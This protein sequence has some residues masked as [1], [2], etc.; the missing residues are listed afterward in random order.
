MSTS[1]ATPS[2]SLGEATHDT[3]TLSGGTSPGGSMIFKLF[4]PNDPT[5]SKAPAFT[6]STQTIT[7]N[8]SYTSPSFT[9]TASGT[10]SW[11]ADYSG[12]VNNPPLTEARGA[13][14]ETVTVGAADAKIT[15]TGAARVERHGRQVADCSNRQR[16]GS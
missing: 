7:C 3:A 4:G 8:G 13:S 11:V 14:T 1:A 5:C 15:A 2:I 10:Y 9:P 16:Y 12:D 6:S